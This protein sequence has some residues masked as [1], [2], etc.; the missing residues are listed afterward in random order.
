[1]SNIEEKSLRVI[2]FS[3]SQI[4]W[5]F[6]SAKFLARASSRGYCELLERDEKLPSKSDYLSAKSADPQSP[7][8]KKTIL[9][10]EVGCKTFNELLLSILHVGDA[11]RT[12]FLVVQQSTNTANPCG[13]PVLAW[14]KLD[15]KY[16]TKNASKYI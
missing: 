5:E 6:W 3:G 7:D 13:D 8:Q 16:K 9:L 10:Y 4:D 11:G 12:A 15:A 1:M 2:E 14:T